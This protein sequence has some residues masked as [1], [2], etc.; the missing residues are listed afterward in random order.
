[1]SDIS[2][3]GNKKIIAKNLSYYLNVNK[4]TAADVCKDLDLTPSTFSDWL[5]AKKYPRIDKIELL[6]N[7]F[8]IKKSDLIEDKT[9]YNEIDFLEQ[10]KVLFDKDNNLTDTQR[11]FLIDFL[12]E[13]HRKQDNENNN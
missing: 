9:K 6:A 2:N 3:L 8:N 1:M 11:K 12:T 7:Y 10:Y 5:N 13:Q 4:K